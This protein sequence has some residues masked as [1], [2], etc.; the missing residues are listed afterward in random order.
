[1]RFKPL[2]SAC[3][4]SLMVYASA[5]AQV[6]PASQESAVTK[7]TKEE[8]EKARKEL[9][10]QSFKLL[11]QTLDESQLLKLPENRALVQLTAGD[12][13]WARD[14]KRARAL[15]REGMTAIAEVLNSNKGDARRRDNS[16]WIIWQ[17]RG[18]SL[19]M[20]AR[21]DPQL[22]LDLLYA[23]RPAQ[24]DDAA[25]RMGM[26]D[27]ELALEQAITVQVA[28]N[29][30]KRALQMAEESLKKGV[31]F[32]VLGLLA[33]LQQKDAEA[34]TKFAT[35]VIKKM[36]TDD[37][38]TN[39]QE[40]F[41]A[42]ELLHRIL[43]P[44]QSAQAAVQTATA[45]PR[46]KPLTLDDQAIRDLAEVIV[47]AALKEP[48]GN[49]NML[50]SID[51]IMPELEKK[52]PERA[53]QLRRKI[54]EASKAL[55]PERSSWAKYNSLM[56]GGSTEAI[57]EEAAKAPPEMRS[58]IYSMVAWKLLQ[59][60]ETERARQVVAEHLSGQERDEML[61]RID[62]FAISNALKQGK[63]DDAKQIILRIRSKEARAVAFAQLARGII[64]VKGE[65]KVVLEVLEQAR[66][67]V[68]RHPESQKEAD[69][70]LQVAAAYALV[71]PA[72]AFELIDP[73]IDQA[74]EMLA[75]AA[76]LDK[77]GSGNGFFR[78]GEMVFQPGMTE[79]YGPLA[80]YTRGL[81]ELARAD[82]ERTKTLADRFQR[83][84][85]RLLARLLIAHS[86]L[87]DRSAPPN[88]EPMIMGGVGFIG[89]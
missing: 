25:Q 29:D 28:E 36:Q 12:L 81:G 80:Q 16:Y 32:S 13:L 41:V 40:G 77:F 9:E 64:A 22:A 34:A 6:S 73:M 10:R 48:L 19:Q 45:A 55:G 4:L 88:A 1:M 7:E 71:E 20:I 43:Q 52:V 27:Q 50:M 62:Q 60:G 86:V 59:A 75:A 37:F 74:N 67:L 44:Q 49:P 15:F 5:A 65:R 23:S 78:K 30:P 46:P 58:S 42:I 8:Q 31:S 57:M 3:V 35:S 11:E 33:R 14:E 68:E 24:G 47:N 51:S 39:P 82:F 61:A 83:T 89:Y 63:I 72:R 21:R 79:T 54:N 18:Q 2:F 85:A 70:L 56:R 53:V 66:A 38:T 87:T 84:D 26:P 17:L 69:A 76:L